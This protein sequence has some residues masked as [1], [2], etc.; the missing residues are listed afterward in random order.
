[1][2]LFFGVRK[3]ACALRA[4]EHFRAKA[5]ASCRTPNSAVGYSLLL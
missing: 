3:L 2:R 5:A 1:L 4:M